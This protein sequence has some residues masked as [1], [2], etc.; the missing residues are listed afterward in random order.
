[1]GG[2]CADDFFVGVDDFAA[3][4]EPFCFGVI[5]GDSRDFGESAWGIE[6]VAVEPRYDL[7]ARQGHAAVDG[8]GLTIVFGAAP[9]KARICKGAEEFDRAVGAAA[10]DDDPL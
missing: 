3:P 5:C 9:A 7:A 2:R 6:V 10:V 8:V 4:C 1:M